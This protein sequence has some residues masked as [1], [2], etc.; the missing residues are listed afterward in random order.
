MHSHTTDLAVY[1][2]SSSMGLEADEGVYLSLTGCGCVAA[3]YLCQSPRACNSSQCSDR[4]NCSYTHDGAYSCTCDVGYTGTS[5]ELVDW[6][7]LDQPCL[8]NGSCLLHPSVGNYTCDCRPGFLGVDCSVPDA[9][10]QRHPC[11]N[12]G[13]CLS[14]L[15][16]EYQCSCAVGYTG[17][18][19]SAL[20]GA[21]EP[22]NPCLNDATCTSVLSGFRCSCAPGFTG[23]TC[24]T[25]IVVS[26]EC[27]SSYCHNGG[28]CS[29]RDDSIVCDCRPGI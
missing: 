11:V 25:E 27:N 21:C 3:G 26:V 5:C 4:G 22:T 12:G 6:C 2:K 1:A 20:I 14:S 7:A 13:T 23:E 8:N 19:C 29:G 24:E 17:H 16:G 15:D 18:N 10:W 9:C 28:T